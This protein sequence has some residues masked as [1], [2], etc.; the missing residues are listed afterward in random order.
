MGVGICSTVE[1]GHNKVNLKSGENLSQLINDPSIESTSI[2]R[3]K[4]RYGHFINNR[5]VEPDTGSYF[6]SLNPATGKTI[7]EIA[8]G[9]E[10]DIERAYQA[11]RK[12]H[13]SWSKLKPLERG[14]FLYKI[15]RILQ[16]RSRE[17]A[18]LET[19]DNGK[20]IKESR[21]TDIPLAISHF[22]YHAGWADKL[23]Y[24]TNYSNPK[25]LGVVGQIIPWNFP[26]LMLAWK[27]A[28]ALAAGNTVILKPAEST[29]LTA[30]LFAEVLL[31]A[32][33]PAGVVNIVTG[34]G[35]AGSALVNHKG[36]AK[37]A[38]TGSTEVGKKIAAAASERSIP[39]TLELGGK[40]ANIV[41]A[42]AAIDEAIEGVVKGI[43]FNQGHV[44]C[45]GSRLLIEE[46]IEDEFLDK[47][48][49]RVSTI[50][51]GNPLD[52]NT[53]MGAIN[54]LEQLS[55]IEKLV[56][57]GREYGKFWQSSCELPKAGYFF[58][59]TI[60]SGLTPTDK[61][62]QE[63]IFGPVLSVLSFKTPEQAIEKANNSR[64]G[65]AAGIWSNKASKILWAANRLRAG[66]IWSNTYNKFDPN[67]AFGGV[68]ESG[69]G[70]EGGLAGLQAYLK[71]GGSE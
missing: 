38:F 50:R 30:L 16:E 37:I 71:E 36:I 15:A 14:K 26:L 68:K 10:V 5:F 44:C 53:D 4:E 18:V 28:P 7:A 49:K 8:D 51:V 42:D 9:N 62:T 70:R 31:Q 66:V 20:P 35:K 65:L 19:L 3:L 1:P 60:I 46:S 17:F 55:K 24:L 13:E 23:E 21:D 29:S 34:D 39:V 25:S 47:L 32:E 45:A 57:E 33:L 22:F 61:L 64:Y 6:K 43:Y 48:Y 56:D 2:L 54:S 52:K 67:S 58:K 41:F 27:V 63:E 11:A 69:W 40:G 59:P 12:A